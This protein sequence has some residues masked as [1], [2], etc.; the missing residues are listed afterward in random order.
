[1]LDIILR[2]SVPPL[3]SMYGVG[4]GLINGIAAK[5]LAG[6]NDIASLVASDKSSIEA[7]LDEVNSRE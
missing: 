5:L 3:Y 7:V 1:M 4:S 6:D 2:S